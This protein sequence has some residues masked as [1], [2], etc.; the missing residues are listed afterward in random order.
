MEVSAELQDALRQLRE[1]PG[2]VYVSELAQ[3]KS[4]AP[5][6][7]AQ[8]SV[9]LPSR[10]AASGVSATGVK[11]V[12][13]LTLIFRDFPMS[14]PRLLLRADFPAALP[15]INPHKAG[16]LVPPCVFEGDLDE[17][18]HRFGLMRVI[19]QA[20][21]WLQKAAAGQLI[22][23]EQGWEP[24][25]PRAANASVRFD[26]DSLVQA[27]PR[28]GSVYT[29]QTFYGLFDPL[30]YLLFWDG[31]DGKT[32]SYSQSGD[33]S[34][35]TGMTTTFVAVAAD[36]DG[37][38]PVMGDYKPDVVT[39]V[40][41][42]LARAAE[43]GFDS[44]RL[45]LNL[46]IFVMRSLIEAAKD[47]GAWPWPGDLIF[48]VILAARRPA[49]LVA[50]MRRDTEFI[51]YLLRLKKD[52]LPWRLESCTVHPADHV[53]TLTPQLL[54]RVSGYEDAD[55]QQ[56]FAVVGCGSVG[57]K[58]ACHLGRAG[59]GNASFI[60]NENF[61]PHN[62]A[63]NA[64]S[65]SNKFQRFAK[66]SM[67]KKQF[68]EFGHQGTKDVVKDAIRLLLHEAPETFAEALPANCALVLDCTA[69]LQVGVAAVRSEHLSLPASGRYARAMFYGQGRAA[70]LLLEGPNR[71]VRVD[72]L[73]AE[74][75]AACR[76]NPLVRY[77]LAG[78]T[79]D[80]TRVFVGDNCA[81]FTMPMS[82]S[83]VS[84]GTALMSLQVEQWLT[85]G[86]PATGQLHVGAAHG[87]GGIGMSWQSE[88]VRPAFALAPAG[89]TTWQ[90]RVSARVAAMM[91]LDAKKWAPKETGGALLGHVDAATRTIVIA[92]LVEA[93]PDSKRKRTKFE[94]GVIGLKDSL[95]QANEDTIGYLR[96]VGTWHSHPMGG[97]H[98]DIDINTLHKLAEFAGGLPMVSLVWAPDGMY[99]RVESS[100][101]VG[102]KPAVV[103]TAPTK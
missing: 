38:R 65:E 90:V 96:Y 79:S 75:F 88:D 97:P 18:M 4:G 49:P 11:A 28:D 103:G 80:P 74:L 82:D 7:V 61:I 2:V 89:D 35:L 29:H 48:P 66:A 25:R 41:S 57:S 92:D 83:M 73:L 34:L 55:L 13:P 101:G 47:D 19:D 54:A 43:L 87:S 30:Q 78:S 71:A 76:S 23:L 3:L 100:L 39:D 51:P 20:A 84:R 16:E 52:A 33:E 27:L 21:D 70:V 17:L 53:R 26:A 60:D 12:E 50:A 44:E 77:A 24:T 56:G 6:V 9:P 32:S 86:L 94:L 22:N 45:R 81:S 8:M 69:S 98:S 31:G 72:D 42:L 68:T 64:L 14:A 85:Q 63:R 5:Y 58:L 46:D 1:H 95:R 102:S 59:F 62:T 99:C 15:H 10:A 37:E 91:T 67:L 40:E 93:P 36:V